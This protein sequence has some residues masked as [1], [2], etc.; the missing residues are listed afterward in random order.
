MKPLN[1]CE[2]CGIKQ[3]KD[4]KKELNKIFTK[5]QFDPM[6]CAICKIPLP[7]SKKASSNQPGTSEQS[8]DS[9]INL[10]ASD[11]DDAADFDENLRIDSH[12]EEVAIPVQVKR[13]YVD[14]SLVTKGLD[15]RVLQLL[16]PSEDPAK[17]FKCNLCQTGCAKIYNFLRHLKIQHK[18]DYLQEK[19][20]SC[21]YCNEG[22]TCFTKLHLHLVTHE[23]EENKI[24]SCE[25][26]GSALKTIY[27]YRRHM[28]IIH[29]SERNLPCRYCGKLFR[30]ISE[31][32]GHEKIH[33][34]KKPYPCDMCSMSFVLP[35]RLKR[36]QMSHTGEK[37]YTCE[38]CNH[39]M[40]DK[41]YL[42][43]HIKKYH[44]GASKYSCKQCSF[45]CVFK[46]DLNL[47]IRE[48][49]SVLSQRKVRQQ[50]TEQITLV[51]D[52]HTG[53]T[54]AHQEVV[55]T[56]NHQEASS[57][58]PPE[59]IQAISKLLQEADQSN[60]AT[61][62]ANDASEAEEVL[63]QCM[64]CGFQSPDVADM[65]THM[66]GHL[67]DGGA[68]VDCVEVDDAVT[69]RCEDCGFTS[70]N[71]VELYEH[72][73]SNHQEHES[74]SDVQT[75]NAIKSNVTQPDRSKH[76]DKCGLEFSNLTDLRIHQASH[77]S[78][79]TVTS[80]PQ[81]KPKN[82]SRRKRAV[83]SPVKIQAKCLSGATQA[84]T[85]HAKVSEP[86][87]QSKSVGE[88][89][90][91]TPPAPSAASSTTAATARTTT[92]G[93][94]RSSEGLVNQVPFPVSL[95]KSPRHSLQ[96]S[97][98]E[99]GSESSKETESR[100]KDILAQAV[101][102]TQ[103][104]TSRFSELVNAAESC[105]PI[106]VTPSKAAIGKGAKPDEPGKV[107]KS[108][109]PAT[110]A[111]SKTTPIRQE[112]SNQV[113]KTVGAQAARSSEARKS[114]ASAAQTQTRIQTKRTAS[115][116]KIKGSATTPTKFVKASTRSMTRSKTAEVDFKRMT[117]M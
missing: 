17:P 29:N 18:L 111:R 98:R 73:L 48:M 35:H 43:K 116:A 21:E 105:K 112:P 81:T 106:E 113:A 26:C 56:S 115:D 60:E 59:T 12:E 34:E 99:K 39:K 28:K 2:T 95:R 91:S 3:I 68:Q 109:N 69:Y 32:T 104:G 71:A 23:T 47:H 94:Q 5:Q 70:S 101:H 80:V 52:V 10:I 1:F 97:I 85:A 16:D 102:E 86:N 78:V 25:I 63:Y 107:A 7:L 58:L 110:G 83:T 13:H 40:R 38:F 66:N 53:A 54:V 19:P 31:I 79:R 117:Y 15:E 89:D 33:L 88:S 9:S 22:F 92:T 64:E 82:P 90:Q 100:V 55:V 46:K 114:A 6:C 108:N 24:F 30:D 75:D 57:E 11:D 93:V 62:E 49:H 76:C 87:S 45:H 14:P 41:D 50:Q 96:T 65:R 61:S 51:P 20:Y 27:S 44:S 42:A 4:V 84:Q 67:Q 77:I 37:P 72:V 36:H 74:H 8:S 103:A